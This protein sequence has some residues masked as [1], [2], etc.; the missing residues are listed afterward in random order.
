VCLKRLILLTL[1]VLIAGSLS[2]ALRADEDA[3]TSSPFGIGS[4]GRIISM[5]SAGA[6]LGGSSFSLHWNPSNLR[7]LERGELSIFHTSFFD[8]SVTYSSMYGSFPFLDIGVL[9]AGA[10]QLRITGI[11]RRDSENM[12]LTDD[13]DN[14]QTRYV[15]GYAR[16]IYRGLAAG[17]SMKLDRYSQGPYVANGFGVDAGLSVRTALELPVIDGLSAGLALTNIIEP[18]IT[19]VSEQSGDP[20]TFRAGFSLWRAVFNRI[21]DRLLIA[22]DI[23]RNRYSET[24]FHVGCEYSINSMFA[25]RGGWSRGIPTFGCGFNLDDFT[26][27]YAYRDTELGGNHLFSMNF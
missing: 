7:Y 24:H 22:A 14:V 5:G 17:V 2:P 3:G 1:P 6:S 27:D 11:E 20:R 19:L 10:V 21:E 12:L 8:P 4:G 23:S 18:D 9:S 26:L 13:L 16:N 15:L 25:F